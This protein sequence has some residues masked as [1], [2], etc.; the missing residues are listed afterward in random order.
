[1][2]PNLPTRLFRL[3]GLRID[4]RTN[5]PLFLESFNKLSKFA[6]WLL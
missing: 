5:E 1:M 6:T 2:L 3:E 4:G